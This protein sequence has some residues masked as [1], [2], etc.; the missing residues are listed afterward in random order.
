MKQTLLLT[1]FSFSMATFMTACS[2][3]MA[4]AGLSTADKTEECMII[5]K[6]MIKIDNFITV[7]NDTSAFHLEE[8]ARAIEAP[9]IT[10]STNK[11]QMLR[12]A[13][14]KKVELESEHQKLGCET[15]KK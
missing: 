10:V 9:G 12:D 5:N 13:N 4:S 14:K 3:Q 7:V 11:K 15:P 6:K 2:S 8:A 1:L